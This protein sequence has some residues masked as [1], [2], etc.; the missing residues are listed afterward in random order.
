MPAA[1]SLIPKHSKSREVAGKSPWY[2]DIPPDLS[3]SGRP[4][5]LFFPTKKAAAVSSMQLRNRQDNFGLSLSS[6]SPARIA[7]ASE[8]YDLL[9]GTSLGLLEA[10]RIAKAIHSTRTGSVP[11]LDLYN[12]FLETKSHCHRDYQLAH[13][14]HRDRYPQLHAKLASDVTASELEKLLKPLGLGARDHAIKYWRAV[15]NYGISKKFLTDNPIDDVDRKESISDEA[16]IISNEHVRGLLNYALENDLQLLPYFVFGFFAG[17][18]PDGELIKLDWASVR[19]DTRKIIMTRKITKKKQTRYP[20]L[21]DTAIAWL[22][23][24]EAR[25]GVMTGQVVTYGESAL[26]TARVKAQQAAG[27]DKWIQQGARH[28]F[29]SNWL[30]VHKD[31]NK[32]ALMNGHSRDVLW[33]SYV[34][35]LTEEEG[36]AYFNILPPDSLRTIVP[37]IA[38]R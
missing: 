21:N 23:A 12:R 22:R 28:T 5:R 2:I 6:M 26:R 16:A 36:R 7:E 33:D 30:A 9:E 32:L 35:G 27:L 14:Q 34:H 29:T 31:E 8:A 3:S 1:A 4:Q 11:F 18:R 37:F 38:T 15:F 10:I 19:F 17:L 20:E 24:Y 25:G 13:R